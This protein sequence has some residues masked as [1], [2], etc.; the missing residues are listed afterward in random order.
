[1]S[2]R[3]RENG[4]L[5]RGGLPSRGQAARRAGAALARDAAARGRGNG[6]LAAAMD[7]TA[8]ARRGVIRQGHLNVDASARI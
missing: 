6:G 5:A 3:R 2:R 1:M 4:A 7:F 8:R